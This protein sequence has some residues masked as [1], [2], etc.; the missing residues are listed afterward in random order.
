M[1]N[2]IITEEAE[3]DLADVVRRY[4]ALRSG[5]DDEF[6]DA[7]AS[8]MESIQSLPH[9]APRMFDDIRRSPV[10]RFPY[11]VFYRVVHDTIVVLAVYHASRDPRGWQERG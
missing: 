10:A 6:L 7:V 5:L 8:V 1:R 9:A 3:A 11:G 4:R 2:L